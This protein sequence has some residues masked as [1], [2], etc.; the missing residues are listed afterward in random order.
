[1]DNTRTP[2]E[3]LAGTPINEPGVVYF[4]QAHALNKVFIQITNQETLDAV[5]AA[6]GLMIRKFY[7]FSADHL[8][9]LGKAPVSTVLAA[10][11]KLAE[12]EQRAADVVGQLPALRWA[13]GE[14]LGALPDRRDWLNPEAEKVL[15]AFLDEPGRVNYGPVRVSELRIVPESWPLADALYERGYRDAR[16]ERDHDPRGAEE[17]QAVVDTIDGQLQEMQQLE[18]DDAAHHRVH[19]KHGARILELEQQ[20]QEVRDQVREECAQ[21]AVDFAAGRPLQSKNPSQ[22]ILAHYQGEQAAAKNIAAAIR[23]KKG[24]P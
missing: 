1:M 21:I 13:L 5:R 11:A 17:W 19:D 23:A 2:G 4:Y 3:I 22:T 24:Q 6:K 8:E 9:Q 16:N 14:L 12:L 18:A 10:A 15:R 7:T 20:L